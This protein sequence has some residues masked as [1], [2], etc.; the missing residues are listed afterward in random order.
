MRCECV[1]ERLGRVFE[2]PWGHLRAS[3]ADLGESW[4]LPGVLLGTL[5]ND[6]LSDTMWIALDSLCPPFS[7]P[8][9]L[10]EY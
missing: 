3:W 4:R 8:F 7:L 2:V 1:L 10:E 6:L 5:L 9:H